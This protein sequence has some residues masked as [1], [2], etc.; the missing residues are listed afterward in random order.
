MSTHNICD[1]AILMSIT[2]CGEL[3]KIILQ[4]SSNTSLYGL[5]DRIQTVGIGSERIRHTV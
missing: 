2:T 1:E 4:L 3:M 5:L